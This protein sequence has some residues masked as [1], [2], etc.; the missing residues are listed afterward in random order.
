MTK[1]QKI[2]A[3]LLIALLLA[4]GYGLWATNPAPVTPGRPKHPPA[5]VEP[6][7]SAVP[8]IDQNTLHTAQRLARL[9]NTPE[10]HSLAQSA[11]EIADHELDLAFA[12][13]LVHLAAHPPPLSPEASEIQD[14][15]REAQKTLTSDTQVV[16]QLTR[17][18]PQAADADKPA[19]QDRLE[20]AQ[21]RMGARAG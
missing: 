20:L 18:L 4:A 21:S 16:E 10:E 3:A 6:A 2:A 8:V 7:E 11:V 5:A 17:Q 15:Q 1:L 19:I 9:A 14:R 12:A 13:T